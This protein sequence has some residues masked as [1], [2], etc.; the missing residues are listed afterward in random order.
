[1]TDQTPTLPQ[2]NPDMTTPGGILVIPPAPKPGIPPKLKAVLQS[3]KF[4]A[5]IAGS[6]LVIIKSYYPQIPMSEE[7]VTTI[8]ALIGTYILGTALDDRKLP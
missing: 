5:A 1:M 7:Q 2:P 4:W 8:C 3:R 6:L